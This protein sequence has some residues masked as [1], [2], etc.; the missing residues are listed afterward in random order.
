[1]II[2]ASLS[3]LASMIRT[4]F[5]WP[6]LC[7]AVD[8]G[9][10]LVLVHPTIL[11]VLAQLAIRIVLYIA[12]AIAVIDATVAVAVV[13][14]IGAVERWISYPVVAVVAIDCRSLRW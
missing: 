2:I 9:T 12:I 14:V 7:Q 5:P 10:S 4:T 13:A 6:P 8:H 3:F 11:S 1:M